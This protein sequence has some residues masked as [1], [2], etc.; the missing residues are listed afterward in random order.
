MGASESKTAV[1]VHI[2]QPYYYTGDVVSGAIVVHVENCMEVKSINIKAKLPLMGSGTLQPGDYQWPFSFQLPSNCPGSFNYS[3]GS[4]RAAIAYRVKA[5]VD[6]AG[7]LK[8]DFKKTVNFEVLQHSKAAGPPQPLAAQQEECISYW[9]HMAGFPDG[10]AGSTSEY[11]T[12]I[13]LDKALEATCLGQLITSTYE[14]E[15]RT[16]T[17]C[18]LSEVVVRQ[19]IL[20]N[21]PQ[22]AQAPLMLLPP[23]DFAPQASAAD[24]KCA[25]PALQLLPGVQVPLPV[26]QGYSCFTPQ[27][28]HHGAQTEVPSS[29]MMQ[30]SADCA[31]PVT[32]VS[33]NGSAVE[34]NKL[35]PAS[36]GWDQPPTEAPGQVPGVAA[37]PY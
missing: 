31:T 27:S 17:G 19:P 5:D 28:N 6:Q 23:P 10:S 26:P 20:L 22:P 7:L 3:S 21:D 16:K 33:A 8:P 32:V 1:H 4:T 35:H 18:C 30:A 36:A 12:V 9:E 24:G 2:N 25:A 37:Y 29:Y 14:L 11:Q 34:Q 15:V 13:P